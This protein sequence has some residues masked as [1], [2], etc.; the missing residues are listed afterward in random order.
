MKLVRC[1]TYFFF[2][3]IHLQACSDGIDCLPGPVEI[4][5]LESQNCAHTR[6]LVLTPDDKEFE[7]VRDQNQFEKV[8]NTP[9]DIRIDWIKHDLIV[10]KFFSEFRIE[11]IEKELLKSCQNNR[12]TL[13]FKFISTNESDPKWIMFSAIIPKLDDTQSLYVRT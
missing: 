6:Y 3:L 5:D 10:G 4:D 1:A 9:C 12:L 13:E 8:V 11:S 2:C 7:L